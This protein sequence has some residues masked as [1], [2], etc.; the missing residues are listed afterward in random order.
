MKIPLLRV[1]PDHR[2][3]EP[4][5]GKPVC[6]LFKGSILAGINLWMQMR[7]IFRK[8]KKIFVFLLFTRT[9]PSGDLYM[10]LLQVKD[11]FI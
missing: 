9:I 3:F 10:H 6:A 11:K 8:Y 2:S 1:L 5:T 4:E 7:L